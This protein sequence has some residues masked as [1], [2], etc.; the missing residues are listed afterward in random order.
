MLFALSGCMWIS[1]LSISRIRNSIYSQK[2]ITIPSFCM[3]LEYSISRG[4]WFSHA[5]HRI[6]CLHKGPYLLDLTN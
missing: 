5:F 2:K 6:S 1:E 4:L 3:N